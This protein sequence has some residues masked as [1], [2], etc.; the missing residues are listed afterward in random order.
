M[1]RAVAHHG[2]RPAVS[3]VFALDEARAAFDLLASGEH[4]GKIGIRI[5]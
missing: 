3:R 4:F 1:N 5:A 2:L